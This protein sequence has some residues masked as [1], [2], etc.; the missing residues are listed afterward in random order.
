MEKK[1]LNYVRLTVA[2]VVL[3]VV[4]AIY[5]SLYTGGM[6]AL[7][8][9]SGSMEPTIMVGDRLIVKNF[10]S[11]PMPD[12]GTIVVLGSPDDDGPDLV[13]RVVGIPGDKLAMHG[14]QLTVNGK[15]DRDGRGNPIYNANVDDFDMV[16]G[17]EK[18]FVLGDNRDVSYDSTEFGPVDRDLLH[19]RVL[20]RY[21][22]WEKRGA[23]R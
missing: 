19:G 6:A 14:G 22:P 10:S 23:V 15:V 4:M 2:T 9:I 18:Y 21:S 17:P 20:F 1:K 8:V 12:R 5:I 3:F 11:D 7:E 13:K 16:L